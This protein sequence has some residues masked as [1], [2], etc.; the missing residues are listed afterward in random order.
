MLR[1]DNAPEF[2][3][4][5]KAAQLVTEYTLRFVSPFFNDPSFLSLRPA[6]AENPLRKDHHL[7]RVESAAP[8]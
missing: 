3:Y 7:S 5:K 6:W 4:S 8:A 1:N 2:A